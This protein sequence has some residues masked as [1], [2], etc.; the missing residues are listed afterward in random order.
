MHSCQRWWFSAKRCRTDWR[1]LG[2]TSK[3]ENVPAPEDGCIGWT[4]TPANLVSFQNKSLCSITGN[5]NLLGWVCLSSDYLKHLQT[6]TPDFLH[7]TLR[8][9]RDFFLLM[10]CSFLLGSCLS[11]CV[12]HSPQSWSSCVFVINS[13]MIVQRTLH[14]KVV[15]TLWSLKESEQKKINLRRRSHQWRRKK[16]KKRKKTSLWLREFYALRWLDLNPKTPPPNSCIS[17][18]TLCGSEFILAPWAEKQSDHRRQKILKL[19]KE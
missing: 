12:Q 11:A 3:P 2:S 9:Q 8:K 18:Q 5:L 16:R 1:H 17:V 6:E 13:V 14:H 19:S 10:I 4:L 7:Q 15:F